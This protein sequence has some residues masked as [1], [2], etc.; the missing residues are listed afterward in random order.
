MNDEDDEGEADRRWRVH[1]MLIRDPE[2]VLVA[3][4]DEADDGLRHV[5]VHDPD[6]GPLFVGVCAH[7]SECILLSNWLGKLPITVRLR[8]KPPIADWTVMQWPDVP[9][10]YPR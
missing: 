8:A 1:A 9:P 2:L 6:S 10:G 7:H 3:H 5:Y 4:P